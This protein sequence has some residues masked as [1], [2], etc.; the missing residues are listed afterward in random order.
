MFVHLVIILAHRAFRWTERKGERIAREFGIKAY[1][2]GWIIM[3]VIF[4][5]VGILATFLIGISIFESHSNIIIA[6]QIAPEVM[7]M[8]YGAAAHEVIAA[9]PHLDQTRSVA[10]NE[11]Y[12]VLIIISLLGLLFAITH[13]ERLNRMFIYIEHNNV[14]AR[15]ALLT[16]G[17]GIIFLSIL[18]L[19]FY[20]LPLH[21]MASTLTESIFAST[22]VK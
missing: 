1:I 8:D 11:G 12:N 16:I 10:R 4:T 9:L 20:V 17:V 3:G 19:A 15:S 14:I 2:I 22:S 5:I 7:H 21:T 18:S 6:E 13:G